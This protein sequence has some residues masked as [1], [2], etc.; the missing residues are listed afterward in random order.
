MKS[1]EI[2]QIGIAGDDQIGIGRER[3]GKHPIIVGVGGQRGC[4]FSGLD[5]LDHGP[6]L[7]QQLSA[8]G[9]ERDEAL[10]KMRI[11]KHPLELSN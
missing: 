11:A 7:G 8:G 2:E 5:D 4:D 3:T 6:I 1:L 9:V 10:R